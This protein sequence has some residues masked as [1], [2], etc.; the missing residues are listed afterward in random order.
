VG[1]VDI[2]KTKYT[3]FATVSS[4]H[5]T[6]ETLYICSGMKKVSEGQKGK[7][8]RKKREGKERDEG[9]RKEE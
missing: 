5:V 2:N 7:E 8:G 3:F 1:F 6:E 9:R 4:Q